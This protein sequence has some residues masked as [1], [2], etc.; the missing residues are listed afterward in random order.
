MHT[1]TFTLAPKLWP[2]SCVKTFIVIICGNSCVSVFCNIVIMPT[3]SR[4][5]HTPPD[6]SEII[7]RIFKN[8]SGKIQRAKTI[9]QSIYNVM[10]QE[11]AKP[12]FR[13][14]AEQ[15]LRSI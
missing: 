9:W 3:L 2:T 7:S 8:N 14:H 11:M 13:V 6:L 15:R 5:K 1:Y 4:T 12:T 10:S